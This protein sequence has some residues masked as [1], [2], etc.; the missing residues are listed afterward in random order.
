RRRSAAIPYISHFLTH[1]ADV[2]V[3]LSVVKQFFSREGVFVVKGLVLSF[4][5]EVVLHKSSYL[6]LFEQHIVFFRT[7]TGVGRQG[8]RAATITLFI[9]FQVFSWCI[10]I[11]CVG[12]DRI[13]GNKLIGGRYLNIISRL[14]LAV[15][16]VIFF[17]SH[18]GGVRIGLTIGI[19]IT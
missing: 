14:Y 4:I 13:V 9:L 3:F 11:C 5:K 19:T 12:V 6:F 18:E 1:W 7:I 16:H 15:T 17:Q 8:L 2:V 10:G